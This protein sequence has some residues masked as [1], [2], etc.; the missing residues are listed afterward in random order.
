MSYISHIFVIFLECICHIFLFVPYFIFSLLV[1]YHRVYIATFK[2]TQL[3]D[4][5]KNI[6]IR[7]AYKNATIGGPTQKCDNNVELYIQCTFSKNEGEYHTNLVIL[8]F[9]A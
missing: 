6:K 7:R 8:S 1:Q 9:A 2:S 3:V 5:V 4:F